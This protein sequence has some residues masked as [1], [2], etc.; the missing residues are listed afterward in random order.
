MEETQDE[1]IDEVAIRKYKPDGTGM[2]YL[3]ANLYEKLK[4]DLEGKK[5][6]LRYKKDTLEI[7]MKPYKLKYD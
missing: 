3:N 1:I 6:V 2:I 5:L 7:C 4:A